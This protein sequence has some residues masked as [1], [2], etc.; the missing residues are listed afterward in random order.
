MCVDVVVDCPFNTVIGC[1]PNGTGALKF[2]AL[3]EVSLEM[4][5]IVSG[6]KFYF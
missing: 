6:L 5:V 1:R 3:K 4:F 2:F